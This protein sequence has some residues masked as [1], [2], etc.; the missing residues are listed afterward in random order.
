MLYVAVFMTKQSS[1]YIYG[2]ELEGDMGKGYGR[3]IHVLLNY[4]IRIGN[5]PMKLE[6]L[7][8]IDL[9]TSTL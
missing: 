8:W 1:I 6:K 2:W 9:K 4:S 3:E 7:M 5:I